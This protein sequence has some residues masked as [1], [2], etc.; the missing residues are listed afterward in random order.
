M[1]G[2]SKRR[3]SKRKAPLYGS[4]PS[5]GTEN[6]VFDGIS[7]AWQRMPLQNGRN[8]GLGKRCLSICK[9]MENAN[10]GIQPPEHKFRS[11]LKTK[12]NQPIKKGGKKQRSKPDER[13]RAVV[14]KH[15]EQQQE[16]HKSRKTIVQRTEDLAKGIQLYPD[17]D[18]GTLRL[19]AGCIGWRTANCAAQ[20]RIE[21]IAIG[22]NA[23]QK[24]AV[25]P[26]R[27]VKLFA[28][29]KAERVQR[30][31][32]G[33][34]FA[35]Q[36]AKPKANFFGHKRRNNGKVTGW[37]QKTAACTLHK[38]SSKRQ[39]NGERKPSEKEQRVHAALLIAQFTR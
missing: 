24:K 38:T 6:F 28:G 27:S 13:K 17:F 36:Q 23:A 29:R 18:L 8:C 7:A 21:A 32:F 22:K 1:I 10:G 34:F 11:G 31:D 19:Y 14:Q 9:A 39:E 35:R 37:Q 12:G 33:V 16:C 25:R 3:L 2:E 26:Y 20:E 30:G 4:M 5:T 15:I